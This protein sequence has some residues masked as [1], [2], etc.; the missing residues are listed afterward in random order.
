MRIGYE[1]QILD[2]NT[3]KF[4]WMIRV[5]L[6][7]FSSAETLI[8]LNRIAKFQVKLVSDIKKILKD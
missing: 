6:N 5:D 7:I 3:Q 2:H 4:S 8:E 1:K